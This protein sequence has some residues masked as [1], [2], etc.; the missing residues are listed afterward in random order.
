MS[1]ENEIQSWVEG[2]VEDAVDMLAKRAVCARIVKKAEGGMLDTA[3]SG[4]GSAA[5]SVGNFASENP[6]LM[7]TGGGA[8]LGGLVGGVSSRLGGKK[9]NTLR[10][11][12][13]GALAGG[14]LGGGAA[15]VHR[16]LPDDIKNNP[17]GMFSTLT[18]KRKINLDKLDQNRDLIGSSLSGNRSTTARVGEGL[19]GIPANY[20]NNHKILGS[21][22]AGDL[23]LHGA[24]AGANI[25]NPMVDLRRDFLDKGIVKRLEQFKDNKS[26]TKKLKALQ[27]EL[28]DLSEA[29]IQSKLRES[30]SG[31][32]WLIDVLK[33]GKKGDGMQVVNPTTGKNVAH[34]FSPVELAK[35]TNAG[36]GVAPRGG[37]HSIGQ[38]LGKDPMWGTGHDFSQNK[39]IMKKLRGLMGKNTGTRAARGISG[40][41]N[42][43]SS[44]S[45]PT[46]GL[47]RFGKLGPRLA[48]YGGVPLLSA[49]AGGYMQDG[50]DAVRRQR[51]IQ[52]LSEP[53]N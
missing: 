16:N 37:I 7:M 30:R 34:A 47:S 11:V 8:A 53:V 48:L 25:A 50:V 14:A 43:L 4:L 18:G 21:I 2:T 35:I 3:M 20:W 46:A 32:N 45:S 12:L 26:I 38:I 39:A 6:G 23:A 33:K 27:G 9:R 24:G 10:N 1:S 51:L 42:T 36:G 13:T 17:S 41:M 5:S 15:L 29:D 49:V 52:R 22:A 31:G 44:A 19:L 40:L 28:S